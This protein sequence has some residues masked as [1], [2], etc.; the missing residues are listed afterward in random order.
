M[1]TW[2]IKGK[3][4]DNCADLDTIPIVNLLPSLGQIDNMV[5]FFPMVLY[6]LL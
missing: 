2:K 5:T 1:Y 4:M 3:Q 6:L